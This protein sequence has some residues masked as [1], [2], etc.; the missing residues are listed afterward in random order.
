MHD[1][2]RD[3]ENIWS[4]IAS[5]YEN[6]VSLPLG[7]TEASVQLQ[8]FDRQP[9][10][11][12]KPLPYPLAHSP[13]SSVAYYSTSTART[14]KSELNSDETST[15]NVAVSMGRGLD[16]RIPPGMAPVVSLSNSPSGWLLKSWNG[17]VAAR[18]TFEPIRLLLTKDA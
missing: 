4:D 7:I 10:L 5:G 8:A 3:T 18:T 15:Q 16:T 9:S 14:L 13:T 12:G 6:A 11:L 1:V 2:V 17:F